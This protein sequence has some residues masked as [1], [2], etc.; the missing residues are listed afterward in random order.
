[1][2]LAPSGIP[3]STM[4]PATLA[5]LLIPP[6]NDL[7]IP[8][9]LPTPAPRSVQLI[10][11]ERHLVLIIQEVGRVFHQQLHRGDTIPMVTQLYNPPEEI[12][13]NNHPEFALE[14]LSS[15]FPE[16]TSD[17]TVS[18]PLP[19]HF[20]ENTSH[21]SILTPTHE[22]DLQED[23]YQE[24]K[25]DWMQTWTTPTPT[26]AELAYINLMNSLPVISQIDPETGLNGGDDWPRT[27]PTESE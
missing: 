24:D 9:A 18:T 16:D 1:M 6:L 11:E 25:T 8:T 15:M 22:T 5:T 14:N 27:P 20:Q 23:Y 19:G 17:L 2:M 4:T 21:L 10:L 7:I 12:Y 26:P 13:C 3:A